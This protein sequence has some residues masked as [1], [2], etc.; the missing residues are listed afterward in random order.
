[1]LRI[2]TIPILGE[3]LTCPSRAGSASFFKMIVHDPAVV[4]EELVELDYQLSL[5]PGMQKSFL[6][7]LRANCNLFGQ[8][9]SIF[10]PN[11][12]MKGLPSIMETCPGCLGT[13]RSSATCGARGSRGQGLA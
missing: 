8:R 7:V 12:N 4:P 9:E 3:L 13:T 10:G 6:R 2:M 11:A 5:L 1:M